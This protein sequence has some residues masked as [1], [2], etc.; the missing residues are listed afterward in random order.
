MKA[1]GV[2]FCTADDKVLLMHRVAHKESDE[3]DTPNSP[4]VWA[5][6][7]G[8]LEDGEDAEAAA[9]REVT[10]ETGLEDSGELTLW[11][12]RV[13]NDVDF[14][15]FLSRC[16]E[17]TPT[18]NG[19][20]D[21]FQWVDRSFALG[22][23]QLHPGVNIALRR[24]GMDEL[25]IAKAIVAGDLTSPQRYGNL[26]LVALRITGT[27]AAY[28]S[29]HK[30]FVWRDP[31][32][33]MTPEFLERCN[34]LP[35]VFE[36]PEG[37]ML[38]HKEFHDR[39]VGTVFLPYFRQPDEVWS[40]AKIWD[41][42]AASLLEAEEMSTSPGVC[43]IGVPSGTK[44]KKDGNVFLIE[45]EPS[46][47]D[48]L[49]LLI[50]YDEVPGDGG[51]SGSSGAGVWDKGLGLNGVDS[52]DARADAQASALNIILRQLKVSKAS[53]LVNRLMN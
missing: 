34:G 17:F 20:H 11:T 15:T 36:H 41:V 39:I 7:G 52:I 22:A 40:V 9:R 8:G 53:R 10:E 31:S 27:G 47:I 4:D 25:D 37:N 38:D 42:P 43:F 28:R 1:A 33:Y 13:C 23:A 3:G 35:V 51:D 50:P 45:N 12:R 21:Q 30:E 49:A 32:M 18:L 6:P 19:E 5:F 14:T 48:H 2:L 46:L 29:Q 44:F 16:E 24:F 26:L